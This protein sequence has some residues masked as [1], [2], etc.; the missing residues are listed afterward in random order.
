MLILDR[1]A[2]QAIKIGRDIYVHVQE[3]VENGADL[4]FITADNKGTLYAMQ[5]TLLEGEEFG[6][7]DTNVRL[8]K[9]KASRI[10]LSIDCPDGVEVFRAEML[11]RSDSTDDPLL[12]L[13]YNIHEL[14][15]SMPRHDTET[16]ITT[17]FCQ[18]SRRGYVRRIDDCMKQLTAAQPSNADPLAR[19][20]EFLDEGEFVQ[21]LGAARGLYQEKHGIYPEQ[22]T[23]PQPV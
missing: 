7:G 20:M 19:I 13:I 11:L 23:R 2:G 14:A 8:S 16:D 6:L 17:L 1:V 4:V 15:F 9:A 18:E 21:A 10:K 22:T 3:L 12:G 5:K